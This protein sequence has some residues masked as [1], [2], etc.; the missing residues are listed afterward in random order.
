MHVAL[1]CGN[2]GVQRPHLY[3]RL[4]SHLCVCSVALFIQIV[5]RSLTCSQTELKPVGLARY[6]DNKSSNT[7]VGRVLDVT[8]VNAA[9][10]VEDLNE[11]HDVTR[12]GK[13]KL[14]V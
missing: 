10:G 8:T 2:K 6:C 9:L 7:E 13:M 5:S 11:R 3:T 12:L 4:F 14:I 1:R